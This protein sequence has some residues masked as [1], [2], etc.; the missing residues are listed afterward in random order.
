MSQ[1]AVVQ[2][3]NSTKSFIPS[4]DSQEPTTTSKDRTSAIMPSNFSS[5]VSYSVSSSS[6]NGETTTTGQQTS[7][8]RVTDE[9][10][11][12]TVRSSNQNFGEPA[13]Q[14]TRR[15]DSSGR[16]LSGIENGSSGTRRIEDVSDEQQ[17]A[18]DRLYEE[19][20]EEE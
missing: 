14:S 17:A 13:V 12:T 18:N 4:I 5:S 20:M 15:F 11:N 10:G 3:I 1:L 8:Q 6:G 16:E 2:Y 19:R 7:H 9:N